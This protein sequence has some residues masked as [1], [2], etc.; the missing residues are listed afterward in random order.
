M[1]MVAGLSAK[2]PQNH[3]K[4]KGEKAASVEKSAVAQALTGKHVFNGTPNEEA[5]YYLYLECASWCG[6]CRREMSNV[7]SDYAEMKKSG[8]EVIVLSCDD[9]QEKGETFLALYGAT[10]P[11]MM[12]QEGKSLPGFQDTGMIPYAVLVKANGD[13]LKADHATPVVES[14]RELVGSAEKTS[15]APKKEKEKEPADDSKKKD[16]KKGLSPVAKAL[17]KAHTFNGEVKKDAKVY[18]YLQSASWCGY[19]RQEMPELV[20]QYKT[21]KK[22]GVELVLVS[23]DNDKREAGAFLKEYKA[24]FPSFMPTKKLYEK[25]P[26]LKESSTLPHA[27]IVDSSGKVLQDGHGS[28]ALDWQKYVKNED[29]E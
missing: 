24:K 9:T 8:V 7:I 27:T 25:I 10:L 21:M 19:C 14:W 29:E 18:I 26:G 17:S 1:M 4:E 2:E 13:V 6:N 3:P 23:H 5:K 22:A 20:E 11:G 16:K 28:I 15:A 12:V